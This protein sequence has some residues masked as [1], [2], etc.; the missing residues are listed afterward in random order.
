MRYR[1]QDGFAL[2][3]AVV[4]IIVTGILLSTLF[5]S[6][7]TALRNSPT[8]HQQW[9]A[10]QTARQCMEWFLGQRRFNGYTALSCP[11]TPSSS[12]CVVPSGFSVSTS[13]ACTTWNGDPNYKTITVSV[14]GL[15]SASLSMQIGD[16]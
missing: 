10:L 1:H 9:I 12:A 6:S 14:S 2:I 4:F 11:S 15:S 16:D 5:L 13:V 8:A 7:T 3:E